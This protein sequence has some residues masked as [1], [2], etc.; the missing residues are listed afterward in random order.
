MFGISLTFL[1]WVFLVLFTDGGEPKRPLSSLKSVT[2][3]LNHQTW[4][5]YTL[6]KE[7]QKN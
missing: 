5:S 2:H 3:T 1:R 7:D 4:H 6:P